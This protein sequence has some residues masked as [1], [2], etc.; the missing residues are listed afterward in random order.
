M[1]DMTLVVRP[2][3]DATVVTIAGEIDMAVTQ[4][5]RDAFTALSNDGCPRLVCDL[6]GVTFIDST[7]LG[8]L[9]GGRKR[10][11]AH[12]GTFALASASRSVLRIIELVGLGGVFET[13]PTVEEAVAA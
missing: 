2:V 4:E 1:M 6:A 7:G 12:E 3:G 8:V 13:F 11:L 9:I 5:I 10:Q